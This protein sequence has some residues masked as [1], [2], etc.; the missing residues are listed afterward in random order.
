MAERNDL[1]R[2]VCKFHGAGVKETRRARDPS[3]HP[4]ALTISIRRIAMSHKER[5][6]REESRGTHATSHPY[7]RPLPLRQRAAPQ[8]ETFSRLS[9]CRGVK[10]LLFAFP[11][12]P[13]A[14]HANLTS[15]SLRNMQR[16]LAPRIENLATSS[17]SRRFFLLETK[18]FVVSR[19]LFFQTKKECRGFLFRM[20]PW[21]SDGASR[22]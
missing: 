12:H 9:A 8:G 20:N 1:L 18:N 4:R 17:G 13:F 19:D 3:R 22:M 6:L 5:G 10:T 2:K 16:P 7:L 11:V 15:G 14:P 21:A